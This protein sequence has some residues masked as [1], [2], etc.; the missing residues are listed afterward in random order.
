MEDIFNLVK[1]ILPTI[2]K[3][4]G[5]KV[6]KIMFK[7]SIAIKDLKKM[8]FTISDGRKIEVMW[9]QLLVGEDYVIGIGKKK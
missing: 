8:K 9:L 7:E 3:K 5:P 6:M 4:Y 1:N 2:T